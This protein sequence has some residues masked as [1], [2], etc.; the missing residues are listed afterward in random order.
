MSDAVK[1][2]RC[3]RCVHRSV[4]SHKN[5]YLAIVKTISEAYVSSLLPNGTM[6]SK[7]IEDFD[8][9]DNISVAC[10]YYANQIMDYRRT[11]ISDAK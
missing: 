8:F 1:E 6:V 2:T 4:C 3:T 11:D 10:R 5:D 9:I 7:R